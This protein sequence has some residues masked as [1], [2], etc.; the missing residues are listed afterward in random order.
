MSTQPWNTPIPVSYT[1]EVPGG[2]GGGYLPRGLYQGL[3]PSGELTPTKK[4]DAMRL[5]VTHR[6]TGAYTFEDGKFVQSTALTNREIKNSIT[7][8]SP[9]ATAEVNGYREKDING[10]R[11]GHGAITRKQCAEQKGAGQLNP[12]EIL[13]RQCYFLYDPPPEGS[14]DYPHVTY[15]EVEE[16]G[17]ILGGQLNVGWYYDRQR[18]KAER[19]DAAND[20]AGERFGVPPATLPTAPSQMPTQMPAQPAQPAQQPSFSPPPAFGAPPAVQVNGNPV[21]PGAVVGFPGGAAPTFPGAPGFS[22]AS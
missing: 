19:K 10:L 2:A 5:S 13:N 14:D 12:A 21:A 1:G 6:I 11:V 4:G 7:L 9:S 22:P 15:L 18:G 16:V 17:K 8:Q 20:A 3:T